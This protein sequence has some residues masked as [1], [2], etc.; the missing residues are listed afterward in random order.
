MSKIGKKYF[1]IYAKMV[2]KVEIFC[3]LDMGKKKQII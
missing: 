3:I 2:P 1:Y